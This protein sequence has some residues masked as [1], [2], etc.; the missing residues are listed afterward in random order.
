MPEVQDQSLNLQ[1][2]TELASYKPEY[3]TLMIPT[4]ALEELAKML[5]GIILDA[6]AIAH[7]AGN[8]DNVTNADYV[9]DLIGTMGDVAR[10]IEDKANEALRILR[11]VFGA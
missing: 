6:E 5:K 10:N 11:D 2:V 7:D 4:E 9:Y 1:A 8:V 3:L